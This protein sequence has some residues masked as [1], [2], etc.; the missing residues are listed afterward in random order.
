VIKR[1]LVSLFA[2]GLLVG[3]LPASHAVTL[4]FTVDAIPTNW[5]TFPGILSTGM[6]YSTVFLPAFPFT[7]STPSN[8][9]FGLAN[10]FDLTATTASDT[11]AYSSG[12]P[13]TDMSSLLNIDITNLTSGGAPHHFHVEGTIMGGIAPTTSTTEYVATNLCDTTAGICS[14]AQVTIAGN[15]YL[16]I[17]TTIGSNLITLDVLQS[18]LLSAPSNLAGNSIQGFVTATG[19]VPEPGILALLIGSGVGGSVFLLRRRRA[20]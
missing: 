19:M 16:S 8:I 9:G 4:A 12:S 6:N 20:V 10:Q 13:A 1:L 18:T 7:V 14:A 3:T 5:S 11:F 15:K 17:Q 2:A